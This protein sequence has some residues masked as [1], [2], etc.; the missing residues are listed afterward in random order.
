MIA[1]FRNIPETAGDESMNI[2][3]PAAVMWA[4]KMS[5]QLYS[6]L[7]NAPRPLR[8]FSLRLLEAA[9][10]LEMQR[11]FDARR[12]INQLKEDLDNSTDDATKAHLAMG[13]AYLVFHHRRQMA[14]QG[15]MK[16]KENAEQLGQAVE[17]A[18]VAT[19]FLGSDL[20]RGV[21]ALNQVLYCMAI[22]KNPHFVDEAAEVFSKLQSYELNRDVWQYRYDDT[23]AAYFE[24]LA[25]RDPAQRQEFL[26]SACN[27]AVRARDACGG[28]D[29]EV[30]SRAEHLLTEVNRLPKSA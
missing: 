5:G 24:W 30:T 20:K 22:A 27:R 2:T 15:L 7:E 28:S 26:K 12:L 4:L 14:A 8:H 10:L 11:P 18:K 1:V 19:Y 6:I 23:L 16:E 25:E 29:L 17:Y 9:A 3:I 21:Y 13:L